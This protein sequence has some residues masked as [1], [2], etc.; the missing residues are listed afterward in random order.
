MFFPSFTPII[1][2]CTIITFRDAVLLFLFYLKVGSPFVEECCDF[3]VGFL[4]RGFN[5][6]MPASFDSGGGLAGK[7]MMGTNNEVL[8]CFDDCYNFFQIIDFGI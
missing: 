1:V 4:D 6:N 8:I 3:V 5:Y 7:Y 2:I